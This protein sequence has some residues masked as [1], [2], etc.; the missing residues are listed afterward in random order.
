MI[1]SATSKWTGNENKNK[2][3]C[4]NES[5]AQSHEVRCYFYTLLRKI[6][7]KMWITSMPSKKITHMED[8]NDKIS[9]THIHNNLFI[10]SELCFSNM[11]KWRIIRNV[12]LIDNV[13]KVFIPFRNLKPAFNVFFYKKSN[14]ETNSEY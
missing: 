5:M 2:R 10:S 7:D 14:I 11:K 4:K 6:Q 3:T 13:W 9:S 12:Y 8:M 1:E